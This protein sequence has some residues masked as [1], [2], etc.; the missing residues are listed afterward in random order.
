MQSFKNLLRLKLW[1]SKWSIVVNIL[2]VLGMHLRSEVLRCNVLHPSFE[3]ICFYPQLFI[4]VASA[5]K[6]QLP[7]SIQT[8]DYSPSPHRHLPSLPYPK[9]A[10]S[11]FSFTLCCYLCLISTRYL[12]VCLSSISLTVM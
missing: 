1:T 10:S 7:D 3:S 4:L 5:S 2:C 6:A 9:Q 8:C 11:L 12:F